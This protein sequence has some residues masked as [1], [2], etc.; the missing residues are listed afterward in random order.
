MII[1]TNF[2][3]FFLNNDKS[4]TVINRVLLLPHQYF[5]HNLDR[6]QWNNRIWY[7]YSLLNCDKP[8]WQLIDPFFRKMT[9]YFYNCH[10]TDFKAFF[11]HLNVWYGLNKV[12]QVNKE[13]LKIFCDLNVSTLLIFLLLLKLFLIL[14]SFRREFMFSCFLKV[15]FIDFLSSFFVKS[16]DTVSSCD[17]I[18]H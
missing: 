10:W 4:Q 3:T 5:D 17:E 11:I 13:R 7:F 6:C 8:G 15:F 16:L 18:I 14:N 12:S 1:I 2:F 9:L